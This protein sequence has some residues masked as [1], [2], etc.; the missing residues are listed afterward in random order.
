MQGVVIPLG[1]I[2]RLAA[3]VGG[4]A[5][6][7]HDLSLHVDSFVVVITQL[8]RRHAKAAIDHVGLHVAIAR[9][10]SCKP[11]IRPIIAFADPDRLPLLRT[12][13]RD[14][15]LHRAARLDFHAGMR[16]LLDVATSVACR[17]QPP[18]LIIA[19]HDLYCLRHARRAGQASLQSGVG[20]LFHIAKKFLGSNRAVHRVEQLLL[21]RQFL[22]HAG[23]C[24]R[25]GHRQGEDGRTCA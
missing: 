6:H 14:Q 21:F 8:R 7:Q 1:N 15:D 16:K 19:L 23:L 25:G 10:A 17:C 20:K 9:H 12:R 4:L 2:L 5:L 24:L 22:L 18:C 3:A 13:R 11:A